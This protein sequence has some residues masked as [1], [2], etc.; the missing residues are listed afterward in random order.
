VPLEHALTTIFNGKMELDLPAGAGGVDSLGASSAMALICANEGPY[1]QIYLTSSIDLAQQQI[2]LA[3]VALV[4]A[5][6]P[7]LVT[8]A[9]SVIDREQAAIGQL[10]TWQEE[11]FDPP[12]SP[13]GDLARMN[14]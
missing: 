14:H 2:D 1:D 13:A 11:W 5:T 3:Q 7:D 4:Y 9:Q 12:A 8:Y 6:Q 10:L